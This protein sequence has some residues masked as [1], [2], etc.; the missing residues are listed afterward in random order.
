MSTTIFASGWRR[1]LLSQKFVHVLRDG[2][3]V[4]PVGFRRG[5]RLG[6]SHRIKGISGSQELFSQLHASLAHLRETFLPSLVY[7]YCALF[8]GEIQAASSLGM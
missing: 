3:D 7:E 2:G 1:L 6:D 4:F 5:L 8:T